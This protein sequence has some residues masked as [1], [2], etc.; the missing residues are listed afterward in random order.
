MKRGA[1]RKQ[2]LVPRIGVSSMTSFYCWFFDLIIRSPT[3][4]GADTLCQALLW[5]LPV[6]PVP[7]FAHACVWHFEG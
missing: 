3:V 7:P 1:R 4:H 2:T 5:L 6:A